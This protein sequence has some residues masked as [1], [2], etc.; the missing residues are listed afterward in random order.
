MKGY[1][2]NYFEAVVAKRLSAVEAD[3]LCSNQHEFNGTTEF[4]KL[5]GKDK[6]I[7]DA[8]IIYLADDE[9][10]FIKSPCK[11]TWY[12]ARENHPTR[13]E[14]RL[15]YQT[16]SSLSLAE[17]GDL[18]ILCKGKDNRLIVFITE[19]GST[20]EN[21]LIW[22]FDLD[23]DVILHKYDFVEFENNRSEL[24]YLG[25]LI[26][27]ELG[28]DISDNFVE[29][30]Y[31]EI[32]NKEFPTGFPYTKVFSQF[33]RSKSKI[34]SSIKNPDEAIIHWMEFEEILFRTFEKFIIEKQI[35]KGF[36]TVDEFISYSL[37][38]QN[39]RKARAG[40]A[41]EN[42]LY[43]IFTDNSVKF[44]CNE[45]TE[46][47]S[48]PDFLFPG[49][50]EYKNPDYPTKNLR[51]LAVKTSCKDR[52]RQVLAEAKRIPQ[53]HLITLE[54]GISEDQTNEMIS[55]NLQLVLPQSILPSYNEKQRSKLIT[56]KDFISLVN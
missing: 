46:L 26:L 11:L 44:S 38:V 2:S 21:Q 41:F 3:A 24:T 42:H 10:D 7:F 36:S 45:K 25:N 51:M 17:A 32:I 30:N 29:N 43:Q 27:E 23:E 5:L 6:N 55:M 35:K 20:K 40:K 49:I 1:L 19:N 16:T 22:L 37:S 33:A 34:R 18:L 52:W 50:K 47:K 31:L 48:R 13:T 4:K 9:T 54:P 12:D 39:R 28:I 56:L 14:Y 8:F 15:Y 53:K